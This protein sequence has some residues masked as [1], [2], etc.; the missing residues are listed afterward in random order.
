M[1]V[2]TSKAIEA[3]PWAAMDAIVKLV[4]EPTGPEWFTVKQFGTRY[5]FGAS[6]AMRNVQGLMDAGKLDFWK[7]SGIIP[8]KYRV[9]PTTSSK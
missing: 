7:G 6:R 4:P 2:K 9:K 8:N 1:P 5:G 3:N